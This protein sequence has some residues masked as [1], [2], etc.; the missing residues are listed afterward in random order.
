MPKP[1]DVVGMR[2]NLHG[3]RDAVEQLKCIAP[4]IGCGRTIT[5]LDYL[6]WDGLTLKEY[7][8][9]G[10]CKECQDK[11]FKD[12]EEDEECDGTLHPN[13]SCEEYDAFRRPEHPMCSGSRCSCDNPCCTA[14][15]IEGYPAIT[16]GSQ[17]C[18]VHGGEE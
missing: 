14:D 13:A 1:A 15:V 2:L 3:G 17:H 6:G 11:V 10:W 16:C 18:R 5:Q 9:S 7:T 12:P 4:P 8:Q